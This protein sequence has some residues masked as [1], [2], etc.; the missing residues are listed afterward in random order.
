MEYGNNVFIHCKAGRGRS[1]AVAICWVA[2]HHRLSLEAAQQYLLERRSKVRKTLYK[3][4][5][6]N[7]FYSKYCLNRSPL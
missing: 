7:A 2:Y 4:K 6:V 1:G 3:Q 5:N